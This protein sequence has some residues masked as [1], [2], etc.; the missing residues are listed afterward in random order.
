VSA[1]AIPHQDRSFDEFVA[2]RSTR[3]LR[4]AFLLCGDRGDAEDLLQGALMRVAPRW[5]R[6][7]LAPDAY[8]HRVLLNLVRDRHRR[9]G[10][11]VSEQP[12]DA[13]EPDAQVVDHAPSVTERDAILRAVAQ[14]PQRQ[15]EVVIL[16]FF[17]DLSVSETAAA[18]GSSAGTVKTHTSR[19]LSTLRGSLTDAPQPSPTEVPGAE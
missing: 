12:L 4:T 3:L 14:L 5:D 2:Q 8:T 7:R 13:H 6:A 10:R 1:V 17:A 19:A 9:A 16:R 11:R 15:R 18:I